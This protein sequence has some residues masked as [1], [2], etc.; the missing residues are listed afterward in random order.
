MRILPFTSSGLAE[1]HWIVH[2]D[3]RWRTVAKQFHQIFLSFE[4]CWGRN[5]GS[6]HALHDFGAAIR[7]GS[8]SGRASGCLAGL[9]PGNG[10]NEVVFSHFLRGEC[11]HDAA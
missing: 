1:R 8:A 10:L 9:D 4:M 5:P 7:W 6:H 2:Q 11:A 3:P